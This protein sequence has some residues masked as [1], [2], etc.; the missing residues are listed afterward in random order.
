MLL[1]KGVGVVVACD[2]VWDGDCDWR[3]WR[4][5]IGSGLRVYIRSPRE[6]DGFDVLVEVEGEGDA[7]GMRGRR[8][9]EGI[10]RMG[11]GLI[12]MAVG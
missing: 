10:E 5:V 3:D 9:L 2:W 6:R 7:E 12:G 4:K 8:R 11:R 1:G